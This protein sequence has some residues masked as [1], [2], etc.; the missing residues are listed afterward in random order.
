MNTTS[1][2]IKCSKFC[3]NSSSLRSRFG[4][5]RSVWPDVFLGLPEACYHGDKA[6]S[7]VGSPAGESGE[8]EEGDEIK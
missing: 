7:G 1:G 8:R 6:Y 5:A 4:Y 3:F 2:S